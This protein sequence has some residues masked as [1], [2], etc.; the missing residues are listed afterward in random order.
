[1]SG[2]CKDCGHTACICEEIKAKQIT[3]KDD[4][5]PA[6]PHPETAIELRDAC[7]KPIMT[8]VYYPSLGMSLRDYLAGQALNG[9]LSDPEVDQI[10]SD[11]ARAAYELA[12][13]MLAERKK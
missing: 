8:R 1:M 4:G 7:G 11:L 13:A 6:F 12:D 2:Y 3:A 5:G 10:P 9:L